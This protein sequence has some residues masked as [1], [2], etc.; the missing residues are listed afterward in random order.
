MS[1]LRENP[2]KLFEVF[3][4]VG[5]PTAHKSE[6][7]I[8][9]K[10][11]L[12]FNDEE[13]LKSVPKFAFPCDTERYTTTVD[14]F[15]FTLTDL[16]SKFRFGFC[17]HATGAQTCLCIV[18]F[19]PWF[20]VFYNLL[21]ILAEITNRTDDN[22]VTAMLRAAYVQEVPG[23]GLPVTIV[24][25]QEMMSFKA[26]EVNKLPSIPASRNLLEYYNAVD[27]ENMMTIFASMLH[28]RRIIVTS[29]KLS[30]LTAVVYASS[31]L[32]Y[33][34]Y[35][36][37]LFIPVL[38]EFLK[39]YLSAPMPFVI[40]VHV[41]LMEKVNK[42]E[43]GDAV[44]VDADNNKV[45]TQY[46]DLVDLPEEVS[47]Y[48]KKYLK[49]EKLSASMQG[50]GDA[51]SKTFMMS[52]VK[53]IGGYRD[54]LKFTEGE[55]IT[56]SPEA[57]VQSRPLSMQPF[58]QNML[59]LQIF[60]QFIVDRLD[61]LNCGAGFADLFEQECLVHADKLNS[62][63]RYNEWLGKMKKQ[64]KKLQK[65]GK[66]VWSDF[67]VKVKT[68]GKKAYS[69][70]RTKFN[71][72]KKPIRPSTTS[73]ALVGGHST[74]MSIPTT[75][76]SHVDGDKCVSPSPDDND[77]MVYN[78][79][80]CTLMADPDIQNA[81]YK[82]ASAE[83]LPGSKLFIKSN[84]SSDSSSTDGD[85]DGGGGPDAYS[86]FKGDNSMYSQLLDDDDSGIVMRTSSQ[87]SLE[88]SK[89]DFG[90]FENNW[91]PNVTSESQSYGTEEINQRPPLPAPRK[92]LSGVGST[93]V[94]SSSGTGST[95]VSDRL[96]GRHVAAR[97]RPKPLPR[98]QSVDSKDHGDTST[99]DAKVKNLPNNSGDNL[100]TLKATDPVTP[101][102]DLFDLES[103]F[104]N[105][106]S[107]G[108]YVVL[109]EP[110][111]S[112]RISTDADKRASVSRSPAL[113]LG[114]DETPKR[115]SVRRDRSPVSPMD[116]L[117]QTS[118]LDF[119]PLL[120]SQAALPSSQG[121]ATKPILTTDNNS[122]SLLH[123]WHIGHLS[124][125]LSS[126]SPVKTHSRSSP[127][128]PYGQYASR[129]PRPQPMNAPTIPQF[130]SP[131]P[132]SIPSQQ[133]HLV[134]APMGTQTPLPL[135]QSRP[136][137]PARPVTKPDF[138]RQMNKSSAAVNQSGAG[139]QYKDPFADLINITQST[140]AN[141][142]AKQP[143]KQNSWETF[144]E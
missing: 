91:K 13:V 78:R 87:T 55:T 5:K 68:Q 63:T 85:L 31:N 108:D 141:Q 62:Q 32:L 144:I 120:D 33:P 18:S 107:S 101:K 37:H 100:I 111:V 15:T 75:F 73:P 86:P 52:L 20:E 58:L 12:D 41:T 138:T 80:S 122:D 88:Q 36:Q 3:I 123:D 94:L 114:Q 19:L 129:P 9:Q 102:P 97:E 8:L 60:Q 124:T 140:S 128:F 131:R 81:I 143:Q 45:T 4:E 65:G 67:K 59:H 44:I 84:D 76:V 142:S 137:V 23:S 96:I 77:V 17:R 112:R 56:F 110:K 16:D 50:A 74:H 14:H 30:R 95:P 133:W 106:K 35:W 26:P 98:R 115:P 47:H 51:I 57:F 39:D 119:D 72:F 139:N 127:S 69:K 42:M 134:N 125:N 22:D 6:P 34:M 121:D 10:Y 28:E 126:N 117:P 71:D 38:P 54:A 48:L 92:S 130:Y 49:G 136:H 105:L 116:P 21:N 104:S 25:G 135:S 70:A 53:L 109:R 99:D 79:V 103:E 46:D 93:Q 1:R 118:V 132:N 82:S 66:D 2:E 27:T 61:M 40:G 11:P 90:K 113:K 29:K 64:G 43:L 89:P 83:H 7:F 24:S